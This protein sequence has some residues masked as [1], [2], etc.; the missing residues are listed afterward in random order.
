MN[1]RLIVVLGA[2]IAVFVIA[3]VGA[4]SL[5]LTGSDSAPAEGRTVA[6]CA[7]NLV[8]KSVVDTSIP[9]LNSVIRVDISGDMTQCVGEQMLVEVDI[10]GTTEAWAIYTITTP[11]SAL[12]LTVNPTTGLFYNAKP[13]ATLNVLQTN[14]VRISPIPVTD[15]GQ[16]TVTIAKTWE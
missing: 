13:T 7:S 16:V 3:I 6:A 4:S 15:F 2:I 14:G 10:P 11:I 1:R 5:N 12:S 8:V 9:G